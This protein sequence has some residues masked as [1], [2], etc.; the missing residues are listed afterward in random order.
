MSDYMRSTVALHTVTNHKGASMS[1]RPHYS[2]IGDK[3]KGNVS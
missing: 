2:T 3:K 1:Q